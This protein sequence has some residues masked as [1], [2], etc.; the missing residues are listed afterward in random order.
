MLAGAF[1]GKF[2]LGCVDVVVFERRA[3]AGLTRWLHGLFLFS[4]DL[5]NFL[6]GHVDPSEVCQPV[7][8]GAGSRFRHRGKEAG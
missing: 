7:K 4:S 8:H 5:G 1:A 3:E 6:P 2:L